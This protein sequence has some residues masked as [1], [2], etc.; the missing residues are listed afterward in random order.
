M[1]FHPE[2]AGY[3]GATVKQADTILLGYPLEYP[4]NASVRRNDLLYYAN[5]TDPNGPAV[6]LKES[7]QR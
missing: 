4:M 3:N 2:F 7:L 6:S 5:R 1:Q